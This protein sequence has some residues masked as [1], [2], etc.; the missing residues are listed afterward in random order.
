VNK[1]SLILC[2]HNHQPVGNLDGVFRHAYE[3]AYE[4]FLGMMEEFPQVRFVVHNTG[5]LLEWLESNEPGYID[6]LRTLVER[7]QVEVLSGAFYEPILPVI[8]RRDMLGQIARMNAYVEDA[9]GSPARGMWLAERVWEPQL[10]SV[11]AQAGIEYLPLDDYEFMLS[12]LGMEELSGYH[13]TDDQGSAV[14]LFPILKSLRYAIPFQDPDATIT[15]L[16]RLGE[17]GPGRLAVFGDDGEKF[18]VWPGTFGHV[19]SGGWLRR[20]LVA[21]S[22][23]SDWIETTTFADFVDSNAPVG[24]VY[25]PAASYPEMMEWALPTDARRAYERM[26]S[27]LKAQGRLEEWGPFLSGGTWRGFVSK[28][29]ESNLMVRKMVRVSEKVERASRAME[30]LERSGDLDRAVRERAAD[31]ESA[32]APEALQEA[33]TELWRGQCNCAYWHGVFGGLYLPHLRSAVY[34]HLIRS[35]NLVDRA[36]GEQWTQLEVRDHDLDGRDEVLLETD[37]ANVYVWPA[38]GGVLQEFD[39]RRSAWNVLGTMSRYVEAYHGAGAEPPDE[40]GSG[41]VPSIHDP[42]SPREEGLEILSVADPL[43]RGGAV[44]RFL[45]TGTKRTQLERGEAHDLGDFAAAEYD[46]FSPSREQG[47]VGVTMKRIGSVGEAT[48]TLE[49]KVFVEP[50]GELT[51]DYALSSQTGLKVAFTSEWNLAFLTGS[52]EYTRFVL[53]DGTTFAG[54]AR[55][56]LHEVAAVEVRDDIRAVVLRIEF[57]PQCTLWTYPLETASQS[58]GGL[59]RVF[60]GT[61]IVAVWE[62]GE[63]EAV[64]RT[65]RVSIRTADGR[66]ADGG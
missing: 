39:L 62:I 27:E 48:A 31:R 26:Q 29:R 24:R 56:T 47:G 44:D 6:R 45:E 43:P 23:N 9:F 1:V 3:H 5:P 65:F 22:D 53:P 35:E 50:E 17:Q 57:E 12:G 59:E 40:A 49:K 63:V 38:R 16:R 34:E 58:E 36:A 51:V 60:Q 8:P 11:L 32:F 61:T 15:I 14:R 4:P 37:W 25:L 10:A 52:G 18:G 19:Y 66:E 64:E 46:R 54:E 13:M 7:G 30:R 41:G 33:R 42:M 20:F 55:K 21:L 28:Y 2:I